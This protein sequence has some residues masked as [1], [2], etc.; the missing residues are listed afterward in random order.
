MEIKSAGECVLSCCFLNLSFKL[1][2]TLPRSWSGKISLPE[3]QRSDLLDV[4][5]SLDD[6]LN[7]NKVYR[8]LFQEQG[9]E[10]LQ[11]LYFGFCLLPFLFFFA[12]NE[13]LFLRAFLCHLHLLL[14]AGQ[15]P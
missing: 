4:L 14:A 11:R 12:G 15:G 13:I 9:A 8:E 7:I 3:L 10:S 1:C 6:E 2:L 5:Q